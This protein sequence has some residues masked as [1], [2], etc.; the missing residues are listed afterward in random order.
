[1]P[2]CY[3][4]GR[5]YFA[6]EPH[7]AMEPHFAAQQFFFIIF[8]F[9][10]FLPWW[11]EQPAMELAAWAAVT[12]GRAAARPPATI[13]IAAALFEVLFMGCLSGKSDRSGR[14][15]LVTADLIWQAPQ[16][17]RRLSQPAG[18]KRIESSGIHL[19]SAW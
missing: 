15:A 1:M 9:F 12:G 2:C 14:G 16:C 4:C 19:S 13:I 8:I 6:I 5:C 11:A 17:I 7:F 18:H 3:A 10:I